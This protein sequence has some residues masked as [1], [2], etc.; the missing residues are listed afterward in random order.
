MFTSGCDKDPEPEN[1]PEEITRVV[2]VFTAP[3]AAPIEV[4]A[5]DPDLGGP[6]SME[7]GAIHLSA[8]TNYTLTISLYN[9]Y[10]S[11]TD[12]AYNV[13]TEVQEEGAEHQLFFSWSA[14]VFSSPAGSGNIGTSGT[15]NYADEDE[16]GLPLGL[17]TNWTTGGAATG[18]ELRLLL[19]HQPGIKSATTTS[20]DGESDL[21]ITFPLTIGE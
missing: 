5:N 7:I 21:D 3:G 4:V 12:P 13:T 17:V 10:Y 20:A 15:V 11:A 19:K 2:L 16:N 6:Q 1:V 8:E 14:G 18:K 9:G